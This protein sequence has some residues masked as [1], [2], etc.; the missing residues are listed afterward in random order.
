MVVLERI[1]S[2]WKVNGEL[3]FTLFGVIFGLI[4]GFIL[5]FFE[6]DRKLIIYINFPGEILMNI[7]RLM[8]LPLIV[9]SIISSLSQLDADQSGAVSKWAFTYYAITTTCAVILGIIL[10]LVIHP[11]NPSIKGKTLAEIEIEKAANISGSD[12]FL[13]VFRFVVF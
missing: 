6:P 8:I 9:A 3:S 10:V 7:L 2:V 12:K 1:K 5:R 4:L 11:G 13:D